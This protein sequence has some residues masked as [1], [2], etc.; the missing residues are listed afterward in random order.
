MAELATHDKLIGT[1][2]YAAN[3]VDTV[4]FITKLITEQGLMAEIRDALSAEERL[5]EKELAI[6]KLLLGKI[7]QKKSGTQ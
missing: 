5:A 1:V 3:V 2:K 6:R 4:E 7:S